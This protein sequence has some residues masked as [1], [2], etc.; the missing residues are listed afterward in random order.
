[1]SDSNKPKPLPPD[2]F[3]ATTPNI[4]LP[5]NNAPNF[6]SEPA[7]DWEKTNYNYNVKDLKADQWKQPAFTPPQ[8]PQIIQ[9][10]SSNPPPKV[11][12]WGLTQANINLPFNQPNQYE[13]PPVREDYG[14][15]RQEDFG[16]TTPFIHL[17]QNEKEKYQDSSPAKFKFDEKEEEDN[18][19]TK[20]G[21]IPG[22]VWAVGGLLAMFFFA[23]V[24]LVGVY[25]LFLNKT[26]FEVVLKGAPPRS[27]ILID[28]SNWGVTSDDG[29][30]RLQGLRAGETKKIEIKNPNFKCE[31]Q[32]IK[33]NN[34]ESIPMIARCTSTGINNGNG[35]GNGNTIVNN[36][37]KECLEIKKGEY[38]KAAKCAYDGLD[39]LEKNEKAGKMFTVEQLLAAMNLYIVNF[40][41]NKFDINATDM[42]FVERAS[43]FIKKLPQTTVIEVGGHTDNAG[44]DAK[45]QPLSE[46]RAKAVR[47]ALVLKFGVTP[48]M[49]QTKGYGSKMPREDN[50]TPDG[51][52]RNRRIEYKV[53]SK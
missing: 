43:A 39:E 45:N 14:S 18:S 8:T 37:P 36:P 12:E 52:F 24:V 16:H 23:I 46:N 1:M 53:L 21:G 11:D 32:D 35:N 22:W 41:S 31:A 7:N 27:D 48:T 3:G 29:T 28:G 42:K 34:G 26:G 49:L 50:K 20:K 19:K 5:N 2:D 38:A 33:G 9:P 15:S 30:I 44:T 51:M 17:P 6:G 4:K 47:D 40:A 10:S 25:F 13:Q